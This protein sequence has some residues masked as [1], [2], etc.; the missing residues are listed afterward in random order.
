[1]G[2]LHLLCDREQF[3]AA[4]QAA[5][6]VV[7]ANSTKPILQNVLLDAKTAEFEVVATDQQVGLRSI[8][9]KVDIRSPGQAVVNARQVVAIIK[10]STS[11][12]VAISV[13]QRAE[14]S[15]LHIE[16]ADGEYDIP[17]VVGE[18]FPP[19]SFFPS[20]VLPIQVRGDRFET[21]LHKTVFA[22][23]KDRTN[24]ILSGLC[25]NIGDGQLVVAATDGKVL[26]EYLDRD[27]GYDSPT[28]PITAVL[29]AM[30]VNHI[31]RIMATSKPSVVELTFA[32]RLLFAR[33]TVDG[34]L[35]VELTSR[36]VEGTF[37]NYA[38]ALVAPVTG[39]IEFS[40]VELASAVR[41][42]AL[43][44]NQTSRGI[45]LTLEPGIAVF[46]NLNYANG[47]VR[48]PVACSYAGGN[49]KL[50]MN[51]QYLQ[52]VLKVWSAERI[53]IDLSRGLVMR[54]GGAT[55]LI[56]PISIPG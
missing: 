53:A 18:S 47:S 2:N 12:T 26:A 10:E 39:R 52:D 45:V 22:I 29:P 24:A 6:A 31:Q 43:M 23:D 56:M 25:M 21:A 14:A 28:G 33:L 1:M 5:D 3:L 32:G 17:N 13:H 35:Q 8:V 36:L 42:A 16:L 15:Q 46:S 41:R 34:G 40:T 38:A 54:D 49:L 30:A 27:P 48:I 19:V 7:P 55:F 20:D 37:P 44:T 4:V 51:A 11:R 50:G 9:R